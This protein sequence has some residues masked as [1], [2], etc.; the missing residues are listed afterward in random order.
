MYIEEIKAFCENLQDDDVEVRRHAAMALAQNVEE[1]NWGCKGISEYKPDEYPTLNGYPRFSASC[2]SS[3]DRVYEDKLAVMLYAGALPALI[4]A[5]DDKD[6]EVVIHASKA[7]AALAGKIKDGGGSPL[8]TDKLIALLA[9]EQPHEIRIAALQALGTIGV[10]LGNSFFTSFRKELTKAIAPCINSGNI[11]LERAGVLALAKSATGD[12]QF[13]IGTRDGYESVPEVELL[14][15][16]L[17][18]TYAEVRNCAALGLGNIRRN[19]YYTGIQEDETT[20][21]ERK[22]GDY[23][24][25]GPLC[26]ALTDPE[27]GVRNSAKEA[28][29]NL[30]NGI[31]GDRSQSDHIREMHEGHFPRPGNYSISKHDDLFYSTLTSTRLEPAQK[32]IALIALCAANE[33]DPKDRRAPYAEMLTKIVESIPKVVV[34]TVVNVLQQQT[35]KACARHEAT[36]QKDFNRLASQ[37]RNHIRKIARMTKLTDDIGID[38]ITAAREVVVYMDQQKLKNPNELLR[39]SKKNE[40]GSVELLRGAAGITGNPTDTEQ[41]GRADPA[42]REIPGPILGQTRLDGRPVYGELTGEEPSAQQPQRSQR[43]QK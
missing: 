13:L 11:K 43:R 21:W 29:A 39:W 37:V 8:G 24:A 23:S 30:K 12:L 5:L 3:V 14:I 32:E 42:N 6:R 38:V 18:S 35:E 10:R 41:L 19:P 31:G 22:Y 34:N 17:Q 16:A 9:E 2:A 4:A 1:P 15:T 25:I 27:P 40:Y 28:L 33:M 20:I 36:I 7:M 26:L